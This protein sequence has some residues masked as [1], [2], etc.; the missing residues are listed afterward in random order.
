MYYIMIYFLVYCSIPSGR[1]QWVLGKFF[2]FFYERADL[3]LV[4]CRRE[5]IR[6]TTAIAYAR[7]DG[8]GKKRALGVAGREKKRSVFTLRF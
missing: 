8:G 3:G 7:Y 2:K 5:E 4:D 1:C 6:S